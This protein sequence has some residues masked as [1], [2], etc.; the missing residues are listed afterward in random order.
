MIF[1]ILMQEI[2][3]IGGN[4]EDFALVQSVDMDTEEMPND[5]K[6]APPVADEKLLKDLRSFIGEL[7]GERKLKS[8]ASQ[9]FQDDDVNDEP[10]EQDEEEE[11]EQEEEEQSAIKDTIK[12]TPSEKTRETT[13]EE[14]LKAQETTKESAESLREKMLFAPGGRW[15]DYEMA[16]LQ[17]LEKVLPQP[18]PAPQMKK[19]KMKKHLK[20]QGG[21]PFDKNAS[22][23]GLTVEERQRRLHLVHAYS[24][25]LHSHES[26]LYR[27]YKFKNNATDNQWFQTVLKSGTLTDKVSALS[28][29]VTESSVHALE[30]VASLINMGQKRGRREAVMAIDALADLML[31]NDDGSG[32][33]RSGL[34]PGFRKLLGFGEQPLIH[35]MIERLP[36]AQWKTMEQI[37]AGTSSDTKQ[38]LAWTTIPVKQA[39]ILMHVED[40]VKARFYEFIV[41]LDHFAKDSVFHIKSKVVTHAWSLLC[42]KR[43]QERTL[44]TFLVNKLGD[45]EKK[46]A[47]K[48]AYLLQQL[49]MKHPV[50]KWVVVKEIEVFLNRPGNSERAQ[51][52]AMVF[53]NQIILSNRPADILTGRYLVNIYFNYFKKLIETEDA[54]K[55]KSGSKTRTRD[56]TE[57]SMGSKMMPAIL[58]GI[59]RSFPFAS[60]SLAEEDIEKV[61]VDASLKKLWDDKSLDQ[62]LDEHTA[63]LFRLSH[64]QHVALTTSVQ[65]LHLIFLIVFRSETFKKNNTSKMAIHKMHVVNQQTARRYYRALYSILW[66]P[67]ITQSSRPHALLLNLIFKSLLQCH[68]TPTFFAFIKR[69]AQ[70]SGFGVGQNVCG[71]GAAWETGSLMVI[72]EI[73]KGKKKLG[74]TALISICEKW[75]KGELQ[76]VDATS[77][78]RGGLFSDDDEEH[79]VDAPDPDDPSE[80]ANMSSDTKNAENEPAEGEKTTT[81]TATDKLHQYDPLN[82][83]PEFSRAEL[84]PP[85]ELT[86]LSRH[87]HP[88]VALF[89]ETLLYQ[90]AT[91]PNTLSETN[92]IRYPSD[93]LQDFT[94][95]HFLDKFVF[96]NPKQIPKA[97]EHGQKHGKALKGQHGGS[98]MQPKPFN[99]TVLRQAIPMDRSFENSVTSKQWRKQAGL[100]GDQDG[101][102][103]PVDEQFY[104]TYFQQKEADQPK[105]RKEVAEDNFDIGGED[106]GDSMGSDMSSGEEVAD[107][108]VASLSGLE[109]LDE[110]EIHQ[111]IM[112]SAPDEV[113]QSF[114][115]DVDEESEDD[116]FARLMAEE[117]EDDSE[118]EDSDAVNDEMGIE[119][120]EIQSFDEDDGLDQLSDDMDEDD[121]LSLDD[122]S[123]SDVESSDASLGIH[124][125]SEAEDSED[126]RRDRKENKKQA[127]K[128][129]RER[130]SGEKK[131]PR[132][133]MNAVLR[134]VA[135]STPASAPTTKKPKSTN[136]FASADDFLHVLQEPAFNDPIWSQERTQPGTDDTIKKQGRKRRPT[137]NKGPMKNK[138]PRT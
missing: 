69:I 132:V 62:M 116:E 9:C 27:S 41:L 130:L 59:N 34:V 88:T 113:K 33:G 8:L 74:E 95:A 103:V 24:Q 50:M 126:E 89:A 104:L 135:S 97:D 129:I 35:A 60:I 6:A 115:E 105:K 3:K 102:K 83:S 23:S 84:S 79:F 85:W 37:T 136:V 99:S 111:A 48:V 71:G 137:A 17:D 117:D 87:Y 72:S 120:D 21:K 127:K 98:I 29:S 15:Y 125:D 101:S 40:W 138:R 36:E 45:I 122:D 65:A 110:D 14:L 12:D 76:S 80:S 38:Q 25:H 134:K 94:L 114:E 118:A 128:T 106:D 20:K 61:P 93:P 121:D 57:N 86:V 22:T 108:D 4:D 39:L 70:L 53:L 30:G 31:G 42:A 47:S 64:L 26:R 54:P 55:S 66:D 73:L 107:D 131:V 77:T 11:E 13:L 1:Q 133:D 109:S 43:E 90:D 49:L 10:E 56:Q 7:G 68:D 124:S 18:A 46:L 63:T 58:T 119:G 19:L 91:D 82:R 112:Q 96:K 75:M 44:L 78:E 92:E 52:Y 51:Y 123:G 81:K 100:E 28:L 67:R 16:S 5:A 32:D 2:L